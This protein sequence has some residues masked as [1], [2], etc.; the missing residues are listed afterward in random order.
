M[1]DQ[2]VEERYRIPRAVIEELIRIIEDDIS[3]VCTRSHALDATTK[4]SI[5]TKNI[6]FVTRFVFGKQF[7]PVYR[8]RIYCSYAQYFRCHEC[9][10][11]CNDSIQ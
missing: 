9:V 6:L 7:I 11:F 3:P 1:N 5:D 10:V 8:R 2:E 4:N